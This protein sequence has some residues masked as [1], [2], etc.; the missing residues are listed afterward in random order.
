VVGVVIHT[1]FFA[2]NRFGS[3]GA[4]TGLRIRGWVGAGALAHVRWQTSNQTSNFEYL[5]LDCISGL[6]NYRPQYRRRSTSCDRIV[7][8]PASALP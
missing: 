3:R 1:L 6:D 5:V 4:E 8:L 7:L 2:G